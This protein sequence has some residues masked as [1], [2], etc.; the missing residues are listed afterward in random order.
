MV[1]AEDGHTVD[2]LAT[3]S[4]RWCVVPLGAVEDGSSEVNMIGVEY[5][6]AHSVMAQNRQ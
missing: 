5:G 2:G 3:R 6:D 1:N 4:A